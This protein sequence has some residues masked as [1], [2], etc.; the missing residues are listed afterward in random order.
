MGPPWNSW[1]SPKSGLRPENRVAFMSLAADQP[2]SR[3][4]T[5]QPEESFALEADTADPLRV[6]RDKFLL[7]RRANGQPLIYFCGH[8]LGLQ[9]RA[10]R[11]LV[12]QELEAW[13]GLGVDAHFKERLPWYGYHEQFRE[14]GARLVGARPGEVV[15]MNSLTVNLHLMLATFYRPE[16]RRSKI[17]IDEPAFPSDLYAVQ[18][19][20]R[21]HGL[22]TE[23]A[24]L[25]VRP[26]D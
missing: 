7:P 2:R 1:G 23:E 8:S 13:A 12:E 20:I 24:L 14:S 15:M 25:A 16:G 9:P 26:R 19:Q 11:A 22:E 21:H 4:S 10:V 17:L 18:S 6:Y 5:F 3:P